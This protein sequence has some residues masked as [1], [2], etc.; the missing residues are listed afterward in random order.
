M[1]EHI[2]VMLQG[3]VFVHITGSGI[4]VR[5]CIFKW[6]KLKMRLGFTF[7][8]EMWSPENYKM[9][10]WLVFDHQNLFESRK[11]KMRSGL[12]FA[13]DNVFK[14]TKWRVYSGLVFARRNI[15]WSTKWRMKFNLSFV[16]PLDYWAPTKLCKCVLYVIDVW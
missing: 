14:V 7:A 8:H 13:H 16:H 12:A 9:R 5:D 1:R 4:G 10:F 15:C 6:K 3:L 2:S 11:L